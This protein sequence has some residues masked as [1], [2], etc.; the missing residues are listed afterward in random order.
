MTSQII[1]GKEIAATMR[2]EITSQVEEIKKKFHI[3]PSLAVILVGNDPASEIY[4]S[5]KEKAAHF[6]G[7]NS[8]QFKLAADISESELIAKIEELNRDKKVHGI[9]VQL[10]L[11]KHIDAKKVIHAIDYRKDVDG[12]HVINVGKL[13]IGEIEGAEKAMIPCTPLGCLH[14]LKSVK[15]EG[16][17]GLKI[18]VIGA[19]NI[20]GRPLA[21]LLMLEKCTV[22]I[23]NKSTRDLKAE[24]LQADV[25]I[26]AAG[27][28]NLIKADMVKKDV[29]VIDVGINRLATK[30][31]GD[32]DFENVKKVASAITPVPGGVGPMTIS[33]LLKNTVECCLKLISN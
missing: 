19:S 3:T 9:L 23:A 10:P 16:L 25:I 31:V 20:V 15:G 2:A 17:S 24:C 7:M 26:A 14:L 13:A 8:I 6:V 21:R 33:Y 12:F 30:L 4:V 27:V 5:N 18:L 11:P 32:V 1:N 22:T 28:P 29:V